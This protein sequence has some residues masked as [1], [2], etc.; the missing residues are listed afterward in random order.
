MKKK[1]GKKRKPKSRYDWEAI[2]R[3][4]RAGRLSLREIGRRYSI[5]A[6]YVHRK[7]KEY[8][9]KRDLSEEIKAAARRKL[10]EA[11]I[12][13]ELSEG[14]PPVYVDDEII[15]H[16]AKEMAAI[17]RLHREDIKMLR[18]VE[19]KL[20][21]EL[22]LS[23]KKVH[24]SAYQGEVTLTELDI[25]T[26]EKAAAVQALA[27]TIQKRIMLERQAWGIDD[28]HDDGDPIKNLIEAISSSQT[29]IG[30]VAH[31]KDSNDDEE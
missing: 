30:L 27:G 19:Q 5:D 12:T 4:Y 24:V 15:E 6:S 2:G 9:W 29:T 7:A 31:P 14:K 26:T 21:K 13:K 8:G 28:G 17:V 18:K 23:P 11:D 25:A 20:L 22:G 10:L 16:E 3:D 1:Q